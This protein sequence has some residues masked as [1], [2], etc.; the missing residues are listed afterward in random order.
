MPS[1]V[2]VFSEDGRKGVVGTGSIKRVRK[3]VGKKPTFD[4]SAMEDVEV[5]TADG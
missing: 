1:D 2:P 3:L 5:K 4:V